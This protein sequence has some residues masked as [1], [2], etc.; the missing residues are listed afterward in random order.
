[1]LQRANSA[2]EPIPSNTRKE[3]RKAD[4]GEKRE[5]KLQIEYQ[6]R[7]ITS[8]ISSS[9]L[10]ASHR[11]AVTPNRRSEGVIAKNRYHFGYVELLRDAHGHE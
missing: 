5:L 6:R 4:V 11:D 8:G 10:S 7:E 2:S 9:A 1:M 3:N